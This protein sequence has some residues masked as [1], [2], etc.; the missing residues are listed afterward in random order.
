MIRTFVVGFLLFAASVAGTV[1]D[2]RPDLA[3][4]TARRILVACEAESELDAS[5][6]SSETDLF[7]WLGRL[8]YPAKLADLLSTEIGLRRP[9][10][11]EMN[12]LGH[13]QGVRIV[14]SA[15]LPPVANWATANLYE[16][17]P[18]WA[19]WLRIA[20]VAVPAVAAIKNVTLE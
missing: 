8:H 19:T 4:D 10:V 6:H 14:W 20:A 9:D 18:K 12:P 3:V 16:H 1:C 15:A 2:I 11:Y 13:S 5:S 17:H 7:R